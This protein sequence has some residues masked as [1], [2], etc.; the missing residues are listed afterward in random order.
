MDDI[1]DAADT[2][3]AA[4]QADQIAIERDICEVIERAS[5]VLDDDD[6]NLLCWAAGI[7]RRLVSPQRFAR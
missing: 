2:E 4:H 5:K 7:D 3:M 1:Y 6:V